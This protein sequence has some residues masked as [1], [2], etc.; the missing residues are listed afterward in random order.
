[1]D[2]QIAVLAQAQTYRAEAAKYRQ[3]AGGALDGFLVAELEHQARMSEA[4]A[5]RL[6][7]HA[8]QIARRV[9]QSQEPDAAI[10][11]E[12]AR[13]EASAMRKAVAAVKAARSQKK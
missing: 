8:K 13:I 6:E 1:M 3:L 5:E 11:D 4:I 2:A 7:R 12:I 9:A 10:R